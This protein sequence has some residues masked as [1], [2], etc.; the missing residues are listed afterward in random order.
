M[1]EDQLSLKARE[2]LRFIRNW[3]MMNGKVPTMRELM[4]QM[5]YKSPRSTMLLMQEL[6]SNGFLEKRSD[7]GFRMVKD[8]QTNEM[9][10]TVSIPLVGNV[11]C[12]TPILAEENIEAMIQVSTDL[13]RPGA[14]YFLLR[15]IGNSMD[16]AGIC[17]GDIL[18]I[19]QQSVAD[20]GQNILALIDDSAT[21]KEYQ[22]KGN[23]VTLLP[24]STETKYKPIVLTRNFQIQGIVI[25]TIAN[26]QF[27]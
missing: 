4:S 27:F 6:E 12:G 21:I 18:L 14:R 8:L 16:K 7:G 20:N 22:R 24:R 5:N 11:T 17:D 15:A 2:A 10:K 1:G 25:A 3:V 26:N 13:A 9:I 19:K 23:I